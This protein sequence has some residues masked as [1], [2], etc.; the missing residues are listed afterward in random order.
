MMISF[1]FVLL[2]SRKLSKSNKFVFK[3]KKTSTTTTTT[4]NNTR[5]NLYKNKIAHEDELHAMR[6]CVGVCRFEI[7]VDIWVFK[8][9]ICEQKKNNNVL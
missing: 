5:K 7:C 9:N 4:S 6:V 8:I 2:H 1:G 3:K